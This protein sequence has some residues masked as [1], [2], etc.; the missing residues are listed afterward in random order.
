MD[1]SRL[2]F[3]GY[4]MQGKT[5]LSFT[6]DMNREANMAAQIRSD[7]CYIFLFLDRT[8]ESSIVNLETT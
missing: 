4:I 2:C 3:Y 7:K 5:A 6:Q 1:C 8:F